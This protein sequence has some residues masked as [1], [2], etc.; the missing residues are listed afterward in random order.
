MKPIIFALTLGLF[1]S[2]WIPN[3][4]NAQNTPIA[5][6]H[7]Q[8]PGFYRINVADM[9]VTALYDGYTNIA[10]SKLKNISEQD[11]NKLFDRMFVPHNNSVQ[12]SI[13]AYLINTGK[14]LILIDTGAAQCF[15]P[16]SGMIGQNIKAAGYRPEQIDTILLTHLHPDH[17]CGLANNG[18]AAFPN[19]SIYVAKQE[20][21][22]WLNQKMDKQ[23]PEIQGLFKMA[24]N[25]VAPYV[26]VNKLKTFNIGDNIL[27][28]IKIV[29]TPGHTPGHTSFLLNSKQKSILIWGDVLHS[30]AVQFTQPDVAI[31]FD[32]DPKQAVLSRKKILAQAAKDQL[33]VGGAHLPFP[34][35]GHVRPEKEGY[36]WVPVEYTPVEK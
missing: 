13:N 22:F 32:S 15:G 36:A 7:T 25:A 2:T 28:E 35:L 33:L 24:Q 16:T 9:E 8:A 11:L 3:M 27:S 18:R 31:E 19:A 1:A 29:S 30:H 14:N 20:A 4:A 34:G 21:D 26:Q 10:N 6:Q 12:T 17:A 23:P 5:K